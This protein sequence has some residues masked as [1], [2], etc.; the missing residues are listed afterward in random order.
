MLHRIPENEVMDDHAEAQA[1]DAMDH[2]QANMAFVERLLELGIDDCDKA[3]D[4]GTGPGDI[5]IML[6]GPTQGVSIL[7]VDLAQ[8][9][10]DLAKRKIDLARV[11]SRVTLAHKDVKALDLPDDSFDAVFSNTILHHIPDPGAMLAEAARVLKPGGLL[12]IR[13]LYRPDSIEQLNALV[14]Q[15]AGDCDA[16]Q[17]KLFAD[18]LHAA[19]TRDELRELAKASGLSDA[20]VV[21]DTDRHMSLQRSRSIMS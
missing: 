3:L 20:E 18:S 13:D 6:C 16:E 21:I 7:A 1:Y 15:H 17:R 19:L 5:P 14:D 4:L 10:L 8:S 12:L 9:M 2:T 11:G